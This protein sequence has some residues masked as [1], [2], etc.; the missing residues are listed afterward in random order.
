MSEENDAL[1]EYWAKAYSDDRI[2]PDAY[3]EWLLWIETRK[4]MKRIK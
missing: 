3:V 2:G 4:R 1:M